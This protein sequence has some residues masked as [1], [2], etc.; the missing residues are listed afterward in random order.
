SSCRMGRFGPDCAFQCRCLGQCDESGECVDSDCQVGWFGPLCQ[1][2]DGALISHLYSSPT[3][4]LGV[5]RNGEECHAIQSPFLMVVTLDFYIKVLS[6]RLVV[7]KGPPLNIS[8]EYIGYD[9]YRT[10]CDNEVLLRFA[11]RST[12]VEFTCQAKEL[13]KYIRYSITSNTSLCM[14]NINK[15]RIM[16]LDTSA[17]NSTSSGPE[18]QSFKEVADGCSDTNNLC[19]CNALYP[20]AEVHVI[21]LTARYNSNIDSVYLYI[22]RNSTRYFIPLYLLLRA[23]SKNETTILNYM[24][25]V[26]EGAVARFPLIHG[27]QIKRIEIRFIS[28]NTPLYIP[29]YICEVEAYG[30]RSLRTNYVI[31]LKLSEAN[32]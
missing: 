13:I 24:Q 28:D 23:I 3:I 31:T 11:N 29:I 7:A 30:G 5:T 32:I 25:R 12:S 15:G 22:S 16:P 9:G 27:E 18:S 26:P 14:F 17:A 21:G 6:L 19:G 20:N 1:Y 2:K 10:N 4:D 8:I